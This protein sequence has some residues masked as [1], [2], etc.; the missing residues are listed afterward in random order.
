ML[1][2]VADL[3]DSETL[4]FQVDFRARLRHHTQASKE[5]AILFQFNYVLVDLDLQC[6]RGTF[7]CLQLS[8][9]HERPYA[10]LA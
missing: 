1:R 10:A 9:L 2:R 8:L 7:P 4:I 5:R 6:L 3:R